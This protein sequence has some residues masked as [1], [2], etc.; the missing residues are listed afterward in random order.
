VT[1]RYPRV[2]RT[3]LP[4]VLCSAASVGVASC[5][6]RSAPA[7]VVKR[8]VTPGW[9]DIALQ[10]VVRTDTLK[11]GRLLLRA[12]TMTQQESLYGA[13]YDPSPTLTMSGPDRAIYLYSS[14]CAELGLADRAEWKLWNGPI[15]HDGMEPA[16]S[17]RAAPFKLLKRGGRIVF[18]GSGVKTE[19]DVVL[20]ALA[21]P[22]EDV[23]VILSAVGPLRT[24]DG[25]LFG[26]E[27]TCAG[28]YYCEFFRRADG[29]RL[30]QTIELAESKV[31]GMIEPVWSGDS[32]FVVCVE[33]R[34]KAVWI[35]EAPE[36][37]VP[38]EEAKEKR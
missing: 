31:A 22:S 10:T 6:H 29:S 19:T 35:I 17:F 9:S 11:T 36:D 34:H 30:G 14:G 1:I 4:A 37:T 25:L 27:E 23:V 8:Y 28:P 20:W 26:G 16:Q 21:A 5:E 12:I 38:I 33:R 15:G 18:R 3:L 2:L 7:V 32:K 13:D 24:H